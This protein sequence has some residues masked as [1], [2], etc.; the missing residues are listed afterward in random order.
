MDIFSIPFF[1]I[2]FKKNEDLEKRMKDVGFI[3]V[4]HFKAVDGRKFDPMMLWRDGYITARS[5]KDLTT[6]RKET[7]GLPSLGAVGCTASHALLWKMCIDKDFPFII[8]AEDDIVLPS[9]SLSSSDIE[10]IQ[11]QLEIPNGIF[12]SSTINKRGHKDEIQFIGTHF[13]LA[14]NEACRA[15]KDQA[16]PIDIQTDMYISAMHNKGDINVNGYDIGWQDRHVLN[17]SIQDICITCALPQRNEP[18]YI[19][20]LVVGFLIIFLIVLFVKTIRL[21]RDCNLKKIVDLEFC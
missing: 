10:S 15:L 1:Y 21:Q 14:T 12:V 6:G 11:R 4:N 9:D 16:Y 19:A 2:S 7:E 20:A 8:I 13:Y 3:N 18:Y 17:S 5:Y